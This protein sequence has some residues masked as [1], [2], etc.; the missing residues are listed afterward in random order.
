MTT[1]H[2]LHLS[3]TA[4]TLVTVGLLWSIGPIWYLLCEAIAASAFPGYDYAT[5]YISDL[6]VP[7]FG[8][9]QG[10][11]LHSRLPGVMDAGFIG[12]GLFF[13]LGV[14]LI[15]PLLGKARS[16]ALL[17][18]LGVLHSMGIAF[19]GLVAG[20]PQNEK[21]G[22]LAIHGVGAIAAIIAGNVAAITSRMTLAAI[23]LP[24]WHRWVS[25]ALGLLGLLS[26]ILLITHAGLPD[27]VWE[28]GS[29]YAFM[30]WQL[31]TGITLVA[32]RLVRGKQ[33]ITR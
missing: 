29:V 18:V 4:R 23:E 27:G 15:V 7:T 19:V 21:L 33:S 13:L 11:M 10:R 17:I 30:G 26:A 25:P 22:Y 31:L 2:E 20:S 8:E 12:S 28:R 3:P 14:I 16:A 5:F 9:F 6:G 32:N 1:A 24:S